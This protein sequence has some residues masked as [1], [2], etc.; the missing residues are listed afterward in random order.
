VS[1]ELQLPH[2]ETPFVQNSLLF[3]RRRGEPA[4]EMADV[5]IRGMNC[6]TSDFRSWIGHVLLRLE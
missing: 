1:Y 3:D 6:R 4:V 5:P 2:D